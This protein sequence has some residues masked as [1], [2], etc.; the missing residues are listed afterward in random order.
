MRG[1][2]AVEERGRVQQGIIPACAGNTLSTYHVASYSG[3]HPRVCGEHALLRLVF[4]SDTWII[5]ACAGNTAFHVFCMSFCRD[6]P[7]VC[8]EHNRGIAM[9]RALPGSSPR[10]RGTRHR[11]GRRRTDMG[12]IP[13][14]AGNTRIIIWIVKVGGDHP[15]VCGEHSSVRCLAN[16]S[17][18]S[19]PRVRG[20]Q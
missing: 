20:T 12:I 15:R 1:T 5:P 4:A 17:T 16:V 11:R 9:L 18:G 8:G 6:H 10:V 3:D 7:R 2:L 13:A 19:S 14:C